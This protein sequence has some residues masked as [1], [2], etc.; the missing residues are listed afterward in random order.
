MCQSLLYILT[1]LEAKSFIWDRSSS[2]IRHQAVLEDSVLHAKGWLARCCFARQWAWDYVSRETIPASHENIW[3]ALKSCFEKKV[4]FG[5]A[6]KKSKI[7]CINNIIYNICSNSRVFCQFSDLCSNLN[8]AR[9][10]PWPKKDPGMA[11]FGLRWQPFI[12]KVP[13]ASGHIVCSTRRLVAG[14]TKNRPYPV[15]II[16]NGVNT[17]QSAPS[18][19]KNILG[20]NDL[21]SWT[22]W[23]NG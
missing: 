13:V 16:T 10:V 12:M 1:R 21:L 15:N 17:A 4:T 19:V 18:L 3:S 6:N 22:S 7:I 5:G 11:A 2:P 8:L 9:T 23:Q 20:V 14:G